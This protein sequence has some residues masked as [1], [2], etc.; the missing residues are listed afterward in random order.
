MTKICFNGLL[1]WFGR[2]DRETADLLPSDGRIKF[3]DSNKRIF[4]AFFTTVTIGTVV[5][6]IAIILYYVYAFAALYNGSSKFDWLLG[7]F[8][9]FVVIMNFSLEESPYIVGD[10]SY[11]PIAIAILY[12]FALICK[13]VFAQLEFS[14]LTADELTAEVILYPQFWA[15]ILLFFAICSLLIILLT[16]KLFG[17]KGKDVLKLGVIILFSAPFIYTVMRGNTIYFALI[18]LVGFL[19]L[20]DSKNPIAREIS[21][22]LLALAGA[23]KL[24]P[25]FFGV[26]LLKDKK[27]FASIRV[28][29]YFALIFCCSFFFFRN[30]F[31]DF[32]PFI[33]N[34]GGFMSNELRLLANNNLS[35]SAQLY[36]LLHLFIPRLSA[37]STVFSV[38]NLSVL[39]IVFAL[40]TYA[41]IVTK[42]DFSRYAIC[43]AIVVLIPSISYFYVIIF[44]ILAFLEYIRVYREMRIEK[45]IF[46]FIAFLF[47][48]MSFVVIAKNF[49][50]HSL[51]IMAILAIEIVS[52]I[53]ERIQIRAARKTA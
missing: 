37:E 35:I 16:S 33:G 17:L 43:F 26:F 8:S 39:A 3:Y 34:L 10:S 6:M 50:P 53:K 27:I 47:L 46:Y 9:D 23:I 30:D 42:S 2:N 44:S 29:L 40:S 21:L 14:E 12:P 19:I 13:D 36:K 25:L 51:F 7:I 15:A 38:I 48:F 11:P 1:D 22:M 24:Y 52:V 45:R 31:G 32:S 4:N 18:A 20:K 5:A 41:S 28:A 49:I